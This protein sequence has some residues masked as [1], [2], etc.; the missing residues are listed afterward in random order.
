MSLLGPNFLTQAWHGSALLRLTASWV[1]TAL[2][3]KTAVNLF[4]AKFFKQHSSVFT[5]FFSGLV[6]LLNST[7]P[8]WVCSIS[9]TALVGMKIYESIFP[10]SEP[11]Q[12]GNRDAKVQDSPEPSQQELEV[13]LPPSPDPQPMVEQ[14]IRQDDPPYLRELQR[15]GYLHLYNH[16]QQMRAFSTHSER[17]SAIEKISFSSLSHIVLEAREAILKKVQTVISEDKKNILFLL[18]DTG[19][20]KST[21]LCFLRGDKLILKNQQYES[22]HDHNQLIGHAEAVSCTF[23]PTVEVVNDL[24][25]VDFPGFEDSHGQ[26]IRLG[27][28]YAIKALVSRYAPQVVVIEAITNVEGTFGSAAKLGRHLSRLFDNKQECFLG[29]TKYSKDCDFIEIQKIEAAQSQP[30]RDEIVLEAQI[31]GLSDLNLV[32]LQPQIQDLQQQLSQLQQQRPP[33]SDTNLKKRCQARLEQK[34]KDFLQEIGLKKMIRFNDLENPAQLTAC[35]QTLSST[36]SE[37]SCVKPQQKLTDDDKDLLLKQFKNALFL[38]IENQKDWHVDSNDFKDVKEKIVGSSLINA[39]FVQ[40]KPE[41]GQFL[42]LPQTDPCLVKRYDQEVISRCIK[43]Y[44][45]SIVEEIKTLQMEDRCKDAID[46]F[47]QKVTNIKDYV[48]GLSGA[49]IRDQAAWNKLQREH[50]SDKNFHVPAWM[51]VLLCISIGNPF[52]LRKLYALNALEIERQVF[53]NQIEQSG[54]ELGKIYTTLVRLKEIEKLI[55]AK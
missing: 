29:L 34:E 7:R 54:R 10:S 18:G 16:F 23:L 26:L 20:G 30:T 31:K 3:V 5:L 25:I 8:R 4:P 49:P 38:E 43:G 2:A 50:H 21:T 22:Q 35:L 48:L 32:Q 41:I 24:V 37:A 45:A 12:N 53:E 9:A 55:E 15:C 13:E 33:S 11:Q 6:V 51:K 46:L 14:N 36:T 1:L 44:I 52:E 17:Q 39:I 42:H 27:V 40:T 28:E 47:N 19:A